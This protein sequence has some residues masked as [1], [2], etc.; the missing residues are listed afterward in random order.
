VVDWVKRV[1][2]AAGGILRP[3]EEVLGAANVTPSPIV[4]GGATVGGAIAGGLVGAAVGAM[5]QSR[6][7]NKAEEIDSA[8]GLPDAAGRPVRFEIPKSASVAVTAHRVLVFE[9]S[10]LGK[11]RGLIHEIPILDVESV[12]W[13]EADTRWLRGAPRSRLVWIGVRDGTVVPMAM[14]SMG[15]AGTANHTLLSGIEQVRPGTVREFAS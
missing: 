7:D 4:M 8:R 13:F 5:W 2:K 15:P 3:G 11:T 12:D 14:M 10:G 9:V 6:A 1:R